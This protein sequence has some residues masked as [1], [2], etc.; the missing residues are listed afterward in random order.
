VRIR[1][2]E[3][4]RFDW[5]LGAGGAA[6]VRRIAEAAT[7]YDG[8]EVLNEA[9]LLTLRNRGL[10]TGVLLLAEDTE[11]TED[12]EDADDAD[13]AGEPLGFA[14]V[15]GLSGLG[16]PE[17]DLAVAPPARRRGVG[18]SLLA[19]L[20]ETLTGIPLTAWSHGD[21]PG[22]AALADRTGFRPVRALWL[23]RRPADAPVPDAG[24]SGFRLR[25]FR[26]GVD[27]SAFLALNAKAFADHPEQGGLDQ[28]GLVERTAE[29]WFDPAGFLVAE[30]PDGDGLAGFHWTKVHPAPPG[31]SPVGEV[32]VIGVDPSAQ[33][34]GLGRQLL[35]AGLQHLRTRGAGEVV[36]YVEAD[37]VPAVRLYRSFG[38]THDSQDTDVMYAR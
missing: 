29:E 7:A 6:E 13:P 2:L 25:P 4:E 20:D 23:M 37:N 12:T 33:G 8:R 19:A 3:D 32:Y 21:H 35:S 11:D 26:P 14:Y 16:R 28:H 36:L 17:L 38:F 31:E 15:H 30:T 5:I 22:A 18:R 27:D 10:G 24:S 34:T 9:A 1:R